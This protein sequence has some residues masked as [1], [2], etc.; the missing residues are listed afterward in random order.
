MAARDFEIRK[1]ANPAPAGLAV[2]GSAM[3]RTFEERR[4]SALAQR[5]KLDL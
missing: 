1:K 2:D 3:Q 5:L 4:R